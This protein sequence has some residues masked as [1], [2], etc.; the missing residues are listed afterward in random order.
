MTIRLPFNRVLRVSLLRKGEMSIWERQQ[1]AY[2]DQVR[3]IKNALAARRDLRSGNAGTALADP[4]AFDTTRELVEFVDGLRAG[5]QEHERRRK[6][7]L[8]NERRM[9][10]Q[11]AAF[12]RKHGRRP[13][14]KE[15]FAMGFDRGFKDAA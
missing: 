14:S 9:L 13:T 6:A 5:L 7:D 3:A 10:I 15:S 11:R 8:E 12:I 1:K 4:A 2:K